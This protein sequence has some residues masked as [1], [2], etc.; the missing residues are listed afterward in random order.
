ML[1]VH[2]S[3]WFNHQIM[4]LGEVDSSRLLLILHTQ[5]KNDNVAANR[6]PAF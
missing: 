5:M 6:Q 3:W 1:C 4:L 2:G